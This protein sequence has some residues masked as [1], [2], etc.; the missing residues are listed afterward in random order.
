MTR[1]PEIPTDRLTPDQK[2]I[3]D[4][5]VAGPRG[6]VPAPVQVWLRRPELAERAQSLGAYCR[7]GTSLPPRLSEL[8]ILVTGVFWRASYEWAAHAP[9]AREAGVPDSVVEALKTGAEPAFDNEDEAVVYAFSRELLTSRAVSDDTWARAES[10]L[11]TDRVVDLIGVLGYYALVS[12]T[13]TAARVPAPE[14]AEDP[15][16]VR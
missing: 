16:A 1:L 5:V 4:E 7:Y 8:A 12:M 13:L 9:I 14:G 11:G 6:R 3:H 2:R 15:F 10:V